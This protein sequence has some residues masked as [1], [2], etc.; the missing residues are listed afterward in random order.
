[1]SPVAV[2][3]LDLLRVSRKSSKETTPTAPPRL[4]EVP[5]YIVDTRREISTAAG[6]GPV[7]DGGFMTAEF[8]S[9][10]SLAPDKLPP[11]L[12]RGLRRW[13]PDGV[14]YLWGNHA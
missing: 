6:A 13:N 14:H 2:L 12:R 1:V 4:G 10:F 8:K 5:P 9:E 3:S 7:D 11:L